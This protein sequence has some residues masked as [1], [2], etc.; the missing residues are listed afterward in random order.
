MYHT[1]HGESRCATM[2]G[3][4]QLTTSVSS[5]AKKRVAITQIVYAEKMTKTQAMALSAMMKVSPTSSSLV[6]SLVCCS[7]SRARKQKSHKPRCLRLS[8]TSRH[9]PWCMLVSPNVAGLSNSINRSAKSGHHLQ[10][11]RLLL[12]VP[13]GFLMM[14]N[15]LPLCSTM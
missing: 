8:T 10:L 9:S 11:H 4:P 14:R 6:T 7:T 13:R 1:F 2:Q 3:V 12:N 5:R 15:V